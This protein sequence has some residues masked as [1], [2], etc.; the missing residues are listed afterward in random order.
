MGRILCYV[1]SSYWLTIL[2]MFLMQTLV[3][4][5]PGG[6]VAGVPLT[7]L[8]ASAALLYCGKVVWDKTGQEVITL[9]GLDIVSS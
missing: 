6:C 2:F 7:L 8:C 1:R 5:L 9:G 4:L 3:N